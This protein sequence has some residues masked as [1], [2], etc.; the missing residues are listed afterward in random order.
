LNEA[1]AEVKR[2]MVP[3]SVTDIARPSN[4][5]V[6]LCDESVEPRRASYEALLR[7]TQTLLA[8]FASYGIPLVE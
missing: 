6:R 5:I 8:Q 2:V 1:L 4:V 3:L 7:H